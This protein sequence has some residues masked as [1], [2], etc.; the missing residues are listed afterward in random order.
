MARH[1]ARLRRRRHPL[2][3]AG[4][5]A[6]RRPTWPTPGSPAWCSTS[7]SQWREIAQTFSGRQA[8]Y[9]TLAGVERP[10][11]P[12]HP[13]RGQLHRQAAEQALGPDGRTSSSACRTRAATC[14][15]S[16]TRRCRSWSSPTRPAFQG[17][18][19]RLN[20]YEY[21]VEAGQDRVHRPRQAARRR[22]AEPACSSTA[23]SSST[24]RA[25]PSAR[26]PAP[27]RTSPT[28]SSRRSAASSGRSTSR[29]ATARRTSTSAERDGY[30]TIVEALKREN[31]G[32]ETRGA[33][34][35]RVGARGRGRGRR[36]R[37]ADRLLPGRSRSAPDLPR[38]GRQGAA[39]ARSAR[40]D[41]GAGR[42]Q[43]RSRSRTSGASRSATTSSWTP[44]A[45]VA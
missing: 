14:W 31:Y 3:P 34:A 24:T 25:G 2:R 42:H 20:E 33:G 19:D 9:G 4:A 15:P 8:R 7:A 28:R 16:S 44:A 29:R 13:G 1:G 37:P 40:Q 45:W 39:G 26:R 43:P 22:A 32:V 30:A 38:E 11:R 10:H 35:D 36:R 23:R 17:L 41:R 6:V 18:R 12:R 27:S 5:G 21:V